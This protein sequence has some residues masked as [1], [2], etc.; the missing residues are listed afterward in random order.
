MNINILEENNHKI[1]EIEEIPVR[2]FN[3]FLKFLESIRAEDCSVSIAGDM[4]HFRTQFE[5]DFFILGFQKSWDLIDSHLYRVGLEL[6][7]KGV[8]RRLD[9]Y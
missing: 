7:E 1:Y 8:D 9:S 2:E 4:Y 5:R 6:G 3:D